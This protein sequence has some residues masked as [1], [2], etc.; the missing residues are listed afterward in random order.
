LCIT[1]NFAV[2]WQL[3]VKP[4]LPHQEPYVSF[5]QLRTWRL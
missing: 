2:D 5:H 1:A 3:W 4:R